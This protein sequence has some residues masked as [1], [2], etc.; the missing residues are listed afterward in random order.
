MT[1]KKDARPRGRPRSFDETDVLDIA[2]D[3]FWEQ[4]Y[5][6]TSIKDLTEAMGMTPP[7]LYA[8]FGSKEA[9]YGRVLDRYVETFGHRLLDGLFDERDLKKAVS[10]IVQIWAQLLSGETHPKGCM[11]SLGMASHAPDNASVAR[12]LAMRRAQTTGLI[13]ERLEAG[14]DQLPEGTDLAA[15]T[16]YIAMALMGMSMMA[17]DGMSTQALLRVADRVMAAWPE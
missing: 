2:K 9:L 1:M 4:G 10:R 6:A 11:I 5:E 7:S 15:L 3:L 8:A 13:L 16:N 17:R 14:Q 12:E